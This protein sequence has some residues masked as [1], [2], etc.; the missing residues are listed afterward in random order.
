MSRKTTK[1]KWAMVII[2]NDKF[3]TILI[4]IL[5]KQK[6]TNTDYAFV[7]FRTLVNTF[8]KNMNKPYLF[9]DILSSNF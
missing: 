6:S 7:S 5:Q 1:E 8:I 2:T 4:V 3:L 9:N